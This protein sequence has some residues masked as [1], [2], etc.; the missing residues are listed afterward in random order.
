M[1]PGKDELPTS[2]LLEN[3]AFQRMWNA[4]VDDRD[5][6]IELDVDGRVACEGRKKGIERG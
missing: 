5:D 3:A 6:G 4:P 1:V 2:F